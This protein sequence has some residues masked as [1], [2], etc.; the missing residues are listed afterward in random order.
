MKIQV[1][2]FWVVMTCS[3]VIGYQC[4]RWLC[5]LHLQEHG[6]SKVLWNIT[7]WCQNPEGQDL[8]EKFSVSLVTAFTVSSNVH[9]IG[10]VMK[11]EICTQIK[12]HHLFLTEKI[13]CIIFPI[14]FMICRPVT[15][16]LYMRLD[17]CR[18]KESFLISSQILLGCD[19]ILQ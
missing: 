17:K 5:C 8:K 19:T 10:L 16:I 6:S 13:F 2:V 7:I 14:G 3:V 15:K 4:F 12:I 1:T 11:H 9:M 18:I